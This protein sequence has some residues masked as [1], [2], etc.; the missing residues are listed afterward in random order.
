VKR[1]A[2]A[3]ALVVLT[4]SLVAGNARAEIQKDGPEAWPGRVMIGVDPLGVQ[5]NF[6]Q[7]YG[8]SPYSGYASYKFGFNVAGLIASTPKISIWLGGELNVGG[9]SHLAIVEPGI[10]VRITL[11]KLLRIPLVPEVQGGFSGG[12]YA[13]YS[14]ADTFTAGAFE[15]KVGGGAYYYL[16]RHIGVGAETHFAFGPGFV[17]DTVTGNIGTGFAGYWDFLTGARFA[18]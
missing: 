16:T 17:K 8:G 15:F 3:A 5:A 6:D 1:S 4:A 13:P 11:E 14:Y 7:L 2:L 10:F 12:I 18:F 9:Y